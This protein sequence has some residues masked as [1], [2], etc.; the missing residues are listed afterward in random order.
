MLKEGYVQ[1][2]TGDGKGKTTA[3]MGLAIRAVGEG[4]KVAIIQF[5]KARPTGEIFSIEKLDNI[6]TF[7]FQKSTKFTWELNEEERK[8]YI[9]ET[10]EAYNFA[11]KMI[12]ERKYD[13]LILDEILAA[14]NEAF[15]TTEDILR[16]IDNKKSDMEL[17]IT[18]RN[19]PDEL[20]EK[21]DLVTE[22]KMIKHYYEKGVNQ[23]KGIEF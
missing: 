14:R 9:D 21:A 2:Y 11:M 17:V 19:A 18:G 5:L 22:M 13:L 20:I 6:E 10:R 12:R 15:L 8:I 4:L 1:I 23:R 3:A 7:R 16:L